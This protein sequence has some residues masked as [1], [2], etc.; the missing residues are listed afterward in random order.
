M[1]EPPMPDPQDPDLDAFGFYDDPF[2]PEDEDL[3]GPGPHVLDKPPLPPRGA[4]GA[5]GGIREHSTRPSRGAHLALAAALVISGSVLAGV[6]LS[7]TSPK[8]PVAEP[9]HALVQSVATAAPQMIPSPAATSSGELATG[10][11][12]AEPTALTVPAIGVDAPVTETGQDADGTPEIP[13]MAHPEE[14]GWYTSTV[15]PG[16]RGA[17]VMWGHLD[18]RKGTAVFQ[19]LSKLT[20]GDTIQVT[21]ADNRVATFTVERS[22]VYPREA[23]P[24]DALYDDPGY[25]ALRLVTCGGRFDTANQEYTSNVVVFARLSSATAPLREGAADAPV[26]GL[27]PVEGRGTTWSAAAP[28]ATADST[29]HAATGAG[30]APAARPD[31]APSAAAKPRHSARPTKGVKLPA[32]VSTAEPRPAG[33]ALRSPKPARVPVPVPTPPKP[34][35]QPRPQPSGVLR[36]AAAPNDPAARKPSPSAAAAKRPAG[37]D[38]PAPASSPAH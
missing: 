4:A 7:G 30:A 31:P 29:R 5:A 27:A 8:D 17:A 33:S 2:G 18:T 15:A 12:F 20:P 36:G 14:V 3:E 19:D 10:L 35:A 37:P 26:R 28:S 21:R 34:Q 38:S 16:E 22:A 11:A 25:P 6:G 32:P 23:V 9:T 1:A 24:P 13:P